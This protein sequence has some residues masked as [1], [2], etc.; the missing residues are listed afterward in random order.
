MLQTLANTG[1]KTPSVAD[2]PPEQLHQIQSKLRAKIASTAQTAPLALVFAQPVAYDLA[3]DLQQDL[4][5]LTRNYKLNPILLLLTHPLV[6]TL[7]RAA[8]AS[9]AAGATA[10][11]LRSHRGGSVTVHGPGQ[12]VG[13]PIVD[14]RRQG[15]SVDGYIRALEQMLKNVAANFGVNAFVR[16]G[17]TGL[18]TER[19][20]LA[21]IG[22][23]VRH[24][25]TWH[26]F[27]LY[28]Q[29]QTA[30]FGALNPCALPGVKPDAIAHYHPIHWTDA[31][32]ATIV[33]FGNLLGPTPVKRLDIDRL[34]AQAGV[35]LEN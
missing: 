29:D 27:A 22:I 30:N 6:V 28:L 12:L 23:A 18:W 24:G 2:R 25:I 15:F 26:G 11:V 1:G 19:G 3:V 10:P 14:L 16:T 7:G 13:Y 34:T 32:A 4:L 31:A 35:L 9:E 17:L 20:K 21:S 33:A 5:E 8:K